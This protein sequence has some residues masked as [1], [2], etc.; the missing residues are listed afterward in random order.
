MTRPEKPEAIINYS[1]DRE[2]KV[3]NCC[4]RNNHSKNTNCWYCFK[5]FNKSNIALQAQREKTKRVL[6]EYIFITKDYRKK[7]YK[8]IGIGGKE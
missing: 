4:L 6:D 3:C 7:I 2:P 8:K 5:D 1:L